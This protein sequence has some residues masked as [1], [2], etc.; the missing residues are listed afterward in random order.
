MRFALSKTHIP[1]QNNI[2]INPLPAHF[3]TKLVLPET[4]RLSNFYLIKPDF[5]STHVS[6]FKSVSES[7]YFS[8]KGA[9][10]FILPIIATEVMIESPNEGP[11]AEKRSKVS[12][13]L[14]LL[15]FLLYNIIA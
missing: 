11:N 10:T 7:V 12:P 14:H 9:N 4:T 13:S 5:H 3:N 15:Q 8:T 2:Y 6:I 1:Q